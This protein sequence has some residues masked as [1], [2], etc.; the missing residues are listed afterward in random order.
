MTFLSRSLA[1]NRLYSM[2][3]ALARTDTKGIAVALDL[4]LLTEPQ[5]KFSVQ[6]TDC[7]P[8]DYRVIESRF[9]PALLNT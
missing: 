4:G 3:R 8:V 2:I 6:Y 1:F 5:Q 7:L 9:E